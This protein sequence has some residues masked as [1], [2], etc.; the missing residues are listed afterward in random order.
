MIRATT[1][2]GV[3]LCRG[4]SQGEGISLEAIGARGMH[5]L[6]IDEARKDWSWGVNDIA[7]LHVEALIVSHG[8]V[9]WSFQASSASVHSEVADTP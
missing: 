1:E 2:Y 5:V 4:F 7:A 6:E 8:L 9:G 3:R